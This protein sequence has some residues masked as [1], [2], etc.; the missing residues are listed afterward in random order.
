MK[1]FITCLGLILWGMATV[2]SSFL[3]LM[4]N[5]QPKA[6]KSIS[7]VVIGE[8][9]KIVAMWCFEK[10]DEYFHKGVFHKT[11]LAFTD[12]LYQKISR[13]L[14]PHEHIHLSDYE[15][16]E[17]LP[18]LKLAI[19]LDPNNIE[20]YLISAFWLSKEVKRNDIAINLLK[21]GMALN[22]YSY[23]FHMEL[24]RIFLR[25][26]KYE[27]ALHHFNTSIIFWPFPLSS[28]STEAKYDRAQIQLYR[29]YLLEHYGKLDEAILAYKDRIFLMSE[30]IHLKE[31]INQLEKG[32][33]SKT[34]ISELNET[35]SNEDRTRLISTCG[36]EHH[37]E[38][39]NQH[40]AEGSH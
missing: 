16:S 40:D 5:K 29:G 37:E 14:I 10:A 1:I 30:S 7:E 22:P 15:A 32:I 25:S 24:G 6:Y 17:I 27:K 31:R 23:M 12:S 9:R 38:H 26:K 35:I 3:F 20:F 13:L 21:D 33:T 36:H 19:E 34:V 8:T 4:N 11:K 28:E 2:L 18:W 39:S